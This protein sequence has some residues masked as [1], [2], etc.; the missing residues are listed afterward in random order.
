MSLKI[1]EADYH[2]ILSAGPSKRI[3]ISVDDGD[4]LRPEIVTRRHQRREVIS[5]ELTS[6]QCVEML[7][8]YCD[9]EIVSASD[10]INF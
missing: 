2:R 5:L 10:L 3:T 4:I 8:A 1:T 6:K 7:E 9:V